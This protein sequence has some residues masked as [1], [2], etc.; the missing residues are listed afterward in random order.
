MLRLQSVKSECDRANSVLRCLIIASLISASMMF[1]S[2]HSVDAQAMSG[3]Q[4]SAGK[5]DRPRVNERTH[6]PPSTQTIYA[7]LGFG[8][9]Y[10]VETVLNNNG[11]G[12]MDVTAAFYTADGTVVAGQTVTLKP[13]EVRNMAVVDLLPAGE[14]IKRMEGMT[15]TYFGG[16]MEMGAQI[17]LLGTEGAGSVDIPF[18]GAMDYHSQIQ[19]AV[20]WMPKD[21]E[22]TIVL[23]NAS[24]TEI[25][26]SLKY[27]NGDSQQVTLRPFVTETVSRK[28]V[29]GS[30]PNGGADSVRIELSGPVGSLRATGFVTSVSRG[31]GSNIRFYDPGAI[32]QAHLFSSNLRLKKSEPRLVLKNIGDEPISARPRFIPVAGESGGAFEL[33]A[34]ALAA[35]QSTEVDL[36]P[37]KK[38]AKARSDFDMVSAQIVNDSGANNLIGALYSTDSKT[39]TTYDVPLRDSGPVSHSTGSYPWRLDG[40]YATIITVSNTR[41]NA[42]KYLV[43]IKYE[44]GTY[45]LNPKELASGETVVFDLKKIRD[46]QAPD[47]DGKT[48]PLSV[49]GG[50]FRWSLIGGDSSRLVGRSEVVSL[51]KGVSS[52]YSC[53]V[54]CP[55]SFAGTEFNPSYSE[56]PVGG[57]ATVT[58]DGFF[59][60][61]YGYYYGPYAWS[62]DWSV[63]Y[64]S[65][66]SIAMVSQGYAQMG[67]LGVGQSL[68]TGSTYQDYY[69]NDGMDCYDHYVNFSGD[70]T[71]VVLAVWTLGAVQFT[72]PPGLTI[73]PGETTGRLSVSVS[74]SAGMPGNASVSLEITFGADGDA[75]LNVTPN[76]VPITTADVPAG[77]SHTFE[78]VFGAGSTQPNPGVPV[79]ITGHGKLNGEVNSMVSGMREKD[80]SNMLL[81]QKP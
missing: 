19:E 63:Q 69:S 7:P 22:A 57:T 13:A 81:L 1:P 24:E 80:S 5:A 23:G 77:S 58:V 15:L 20:W 8:K 18:S 42:A 12:N 55:N 73:R 26:A 4:V 14:R 71:G 11:P 6:P 16:M 29:E 47:K 31:F 25:V 74:A 21:A 76:S 61:C 53:P 28:T 17:T 33:P 9:S 36:R 45:A 72:A 52:S 3:N 50:Q 79:H 67:C 10:Q 68:F 35:H 37:L 66:L 27:S 43:T 75:V 62:V 40:D 65:V 48:I 54:C 60:D 39:G 41:D 34:V 38:A 51:S 70:G 46:Q 49:L 30:T 56:G 32:R 44:G 2:R 64:P 78:I 59:V